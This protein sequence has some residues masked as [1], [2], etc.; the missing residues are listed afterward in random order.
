MVTIARLRELAAAASSAGGWYAYPLAIGGVMVEC[1]GTDAEAA[2]IAAV[3]PDVVLA[4][5]DLLEAAESKVAR[6]EALVTAAEVVV[7]DAGDEATGS[8]PDPNLAELAYCLKTLG[9]ES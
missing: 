8:E 5:I 6:V 4:L 2:Y 3:S 1:E 7:L 9:A